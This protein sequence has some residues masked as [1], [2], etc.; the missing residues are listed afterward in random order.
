MNDPFNSKKGNHRIR[1]Q[2]YFHPT[3][4]IHPSKYKDKDTDK[5]IDKDKDKDKDKDIDKEKENENEK[6]KDTLSKKYKLCPSLIWQ[7]QQ[8]Q[9]NSRKSPMLHTS[10]IYEVYMIKINSACSRRWRDKWKEPWKGVPHQMES[11][12][13]A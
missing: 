12:A 1:V 7:N 5:D 6:D 11:R 4:P 3:H 9:K 13:T 8:N 2:I 10:M